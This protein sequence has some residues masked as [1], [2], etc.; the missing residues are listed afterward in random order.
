[1]SPSF[2]QQRA[3]GYAADLRITFAAPTKSSTLST[4]TLEHAM[5]HKRL[6]DRLQMSW[7]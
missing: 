7:R 2:G 4:D 3:L 1:M 6:Q 5:A